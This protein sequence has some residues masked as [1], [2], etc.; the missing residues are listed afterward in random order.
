ML[1]RLYGGIDGYDSST[2]IAFSTMNG[3]C[4]TGSRP[5]PRTLATRRSSGDPIGKYSQKLANDLRRRTWVSWLPLQFQGLGGLSFVL[6]YTTYFFQLA[7]V[8]D[9]FL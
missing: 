6:S 1:K 3:R 2:S 4:R 7:G 5:T 8:Q 9:P